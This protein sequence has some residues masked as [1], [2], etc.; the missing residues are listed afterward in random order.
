MGK[1]SKPRPIEVDRKLYE[2]NWDRIFGSKSITTKD[3]P[4]PKTAFETALE[5]AKKDMTTVMGAGERW[6]KNHPDSD[7]A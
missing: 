5:D 7:E 2:D 3:K 6:K 1:G 4:E